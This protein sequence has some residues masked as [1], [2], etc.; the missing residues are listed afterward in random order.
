M[1]LR[2]A[3]DRIAAATGWRPE[4]PFRQTMVDTIEWWERELSTAAP[5]GAMRH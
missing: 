3:N 5:P 1:D 2:G 4:I